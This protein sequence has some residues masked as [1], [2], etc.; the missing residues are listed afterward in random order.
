MKKLNLTQQKP[1]LV[2]SYDLRP[3]NGAGSILQL[4][5]A[6]T[7]GT[8]LGTGA[9]AVSFVCHGLPL[10]L[11]H[12]VV[13]VPTHINS[14]Q[15]GGIPYHSPKLHRGPCNSVGTRPRTDRQTDR[16]TRFLYQ[17][18]GSHW[19]TEHFR[20]SDAAKAWNALPRRRS[21][22]HRSHLAF[23]CEPISSSFDV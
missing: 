14:A 11:T 23:R 4:A 7:Q 18:V 2:A 9:D 5:G 20:R 17:H 6:H 10:P 12:D 19:A 3:A 1:G 8:W 13:F 21:E 22:R 16:Q 15:L